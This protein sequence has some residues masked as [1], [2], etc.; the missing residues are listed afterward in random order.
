MKVN[1]AEHGEVWMKLGAIRERKPMDA[2]LRR[3]LDG[4]AA[5]APALDAATDAERVQLRRA[6]MM[7]A[8]EDRGGAIPGLPNKVETRE[9]T[10]AGGLT[11]RL[12]IPED[13]SSALPVLVYL[14]GC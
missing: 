13:R 14:H 5:A 1:L 4:L 6:L 12:Y 3:Y 7:K 9:V 2:E 10:I 11:A 8:L